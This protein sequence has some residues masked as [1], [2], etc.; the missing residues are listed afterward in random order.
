MFASLR[1]AVAFFFEPALAGTMVRALLITLVLFGLVIVGAEYLLHLLPTLGAPWVNH[2]LALLTPVLGVVGL[3]LVG[4]PV[5]AMFASFYLDHLADAIEAH[6]YAGDGKAAGAR[7]TTS[8]GA[9]VRL[10]GLVILV[11]LLLIPADAL[12]PGVGEGVTVIANGFLLGREYFELAALRH[13]SLAA[14][15]ALRQRNAG[16]IVFAGMIISVL[17]TVPLL[18]FAAPL[19]GAALM[20]HLFKRL[21]RETTA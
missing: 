20:V 3:F 19:F 13:V 7:W 5:T 4:G 6:D 16:R 18:N 14:A 9:S 1:R 12:V 21:Q 11:D 17:S 15:D 2:I 8:L 10:A